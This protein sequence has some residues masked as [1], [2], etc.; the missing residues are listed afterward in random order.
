M[1][2]STQERLLA[3]SRVNYGGSLDRAPPTGGIE[4]PPTATTRPAPSGDTSVPTEVSSTLSVRVQ[5]ENLEQARSFT[6][7]SNK[8]SRNSLILN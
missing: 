5:M 6:I 8:K 2:V 1:E 3:N 7:I 4:Q